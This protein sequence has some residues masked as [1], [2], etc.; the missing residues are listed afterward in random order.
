MAEALVSKPVFALAC[1]GTFMERPPI[2]QKLP[3]NRICTAS[4][5]WFL[6]RDSEL[7][8]GNLYRC[9]QNYFADSTCELFS[10]YHDLMGDAKYR[11]TSRTSASTRVQHGKICV[12]LQKLPVETRL[13]D[14]PLREYRVCNCCFQQDAKSP[15]LHQLSAPLSWLH[16]L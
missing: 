15:D 13:R 3:S 8:A 11:A 7:T 5:T 10:D 6:A 14:E 12:V 16:L 1:T 4:S 2:L 9:F